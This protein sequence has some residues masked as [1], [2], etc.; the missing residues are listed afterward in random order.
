MFDISMI[1]N[2]P[3]ETTLGNP[4]GIAVDLRAISWLNFSTINILKISSKLTFE[5][6]NIS[7]RQNICDKTKSVFSHASI[8][9]IAIKITKVDGKTH[10]FFICRVKKRERIHFLVFK[11]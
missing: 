5:V 7:S 9:L 4:S 1:S 8:E 10:S 2:S 3:G 11:N 6:L